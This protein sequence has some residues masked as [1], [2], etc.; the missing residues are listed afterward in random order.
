[1]KIPAYLK[2]GDT[3][4]IVSTARKIS[5]QEVA[6]AVEQFEKWGLKVVFGED[7]FNVFHQ[8]AGTDE[9]RV[10]DLQK[11]LDEPKVKAII[12]AR[13]GYGTV[14]IIDRLDFSEFAKN[15]KW[16]AGFSDVTVL[17]SHIQQNL[18]IAT[19]H[20]AMPVNFPNDGSF[21]DAVETIRKALFG[22]P[23]SY[24]IENNY[25][26]RTG[27][28]QG[29][30]TGGNLSILYSLSGTCS[31]AITNGKILLLEDLDEYLYHLDRMMINLK[32]TGMLENLSGLIVGGMN[33]MKDNAVPFGKS[34]EE[35]VVDAVKEYN[36]PVCF[37]FP[38]GH[39]KE[40]KAII[41]GGR[42]VLDV[43]AEKS[44]LNYI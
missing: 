41:L 38:S 29:T 10:L 3:I 15:P 13:G 37:N 22:E 9:Q 19:L 24:L 42:V 18:S 39:I 5:P 14:R 21:C 33:D 36:Y 2:K 44:S 26:N 12:C 34:P 32:R 43:G 35:I 25:L 4:G 20:C 27:T 40:N 16:I 6:P 30:L 1:M 17:H 7:L 28:G 31:Q 8:F 23:L 11:M